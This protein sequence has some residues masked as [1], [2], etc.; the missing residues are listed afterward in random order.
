LLQ[1]GERFCK[2]ARTIDAASQDL[3]LTRRC[4]T[5][6]GN[7]LACEMNRASKFFQIRQI[8]GA[9]RRIPQNIGST[10]A[11]PPYEAHDSVAFSCQYGN[12][13]D[14]IRPVA[15]VMRIRIF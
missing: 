3:L 5:T 13:R 4:P 8:D 2:Q 1:P 9:R 15:P 14:P 10:P 11:S 6:G 7:A 12:Q